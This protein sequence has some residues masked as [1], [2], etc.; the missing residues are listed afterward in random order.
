MEKLKAIITNIKHRD[1]QRRSFFENSKMENAETNLYVL[2]N[3]SFTSMVLLVFFLFITP[4]IFN[5]WVASPA[6]FLFLPTMLVFLLFAIFYRKKKVKNCL[7]IKAVCLLHCMIIMGYIMVFD[8]IETPTGPSSFF[9]LL[10]VILPILYI[11]QFKDVYT[12]LFVALV[13]YILMVRNV[14]EGI[15]ESSDIFNAI[16]SFVFSLVS[17]A[18]VLAIRMQDKS[19]KLKYKKMSSID[20]LTGVMNKMSCEQYATEYL[21]NRDIGVNCGLV[22]MDIDSFKDINDKFGHQVG[23]DVLEEMGK[24]LTANFR[25]TDIVG[26]IGGDEFLILARN[27]VDSKVLESKCSQ[28]QKVIQKKMKH[29]IAQEISI[30]LGIV[31]LPEEQVSFEKVFQMADDALYEAKAFGKGQY[32]LQ[33]MQKENPNSKDKKILIVA[34]DYDAE[35][36]IIKELCKDEYYIVEAADGTET[37]SVLS[38]YRDEAAVVI[39]DIQM[40]GM[41]GWQ[42]LKYMQERN[43]Y[44]RIPVIVI[45]ADRSYEEKAL[46]LGA[47]DVIIKPIDPEIARLRIMNAVMQTVPE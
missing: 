3:V 15:M 13:I 42:V 27:I 18:V 25:A 31:I 47:K 21:K 1:I 9:G 17:G 24:L 45:T 20:A 37:L 35:R 30:S 12:L 10:L 5:N 44:R 43:S 46:M 39:L 40:P 41:D 7:I 22:V 8:V 19:A 32:I 29:L 38:Q 33:I 4:H 36:E 2:Q 16:V 26:R 23:D 28:L 6:Y 34:D 11:F 14:K